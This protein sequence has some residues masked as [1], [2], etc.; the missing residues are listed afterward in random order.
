MVAVSVLLPTFNEKPERLVVALQSISS[1]TLQY[2]EVIII[3]DSNQDKTRKCL[4]EWAKKNTNSILC[5]P[6]TKK[7]LAA[8]L[9]HGLRLASGKYI[10]RVDSD[11]IQES[12]RLAFQFNFLENHPEI[13]VVGTAVKLIDENGNLLGQK[14]FPADSST[15]KKALC[16]KNA[17]S[18]ATV[19]Y[20]KKC[21]E[22]FGGYNEKFVAAEDYEMW[23]RWRNN[24]VEFANIE[25]K[26]VVY[27]V[28]NACRRNRFNWQ[29][30]LQAKILHFQKKYLLRNLCGI[31]LV[32]LAWVF[33][34]R[35]LEPIYRRWVATKATH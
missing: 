16:V 27:R 6:P 12:A 24:G 20:R 33:P 29:H 21:V 32:F 4:D 22:M 31:L 14:K 25:E 17:I 28:P 23:M 19:M 13:G 1:Q 11:D 34:P 35:L 3:D 18:H 30:N 15:I 10:A 8:A 26:L 2:F 5:R 9:N 7:N